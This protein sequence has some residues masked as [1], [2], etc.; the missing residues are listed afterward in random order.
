MQ[1]EVYCD[2]S[3]PDLLT[4]QRPTDSYLV[5]GS[6]WLPVGARGRFK[7]QIRELMDR[8]RVGGEVKWQK[9]SPSRVA[10]YQALVRWFA[11][12]GASLRFRGIAVNRHRINFRLHG[13]DREL[14]FYRFYYQL[15]K[16]WL[17]D[18]NQYSVFCDFK[19]NRVPTQLHTLHR[20]LSAAN[21]S[22]Q[23]CRVQAIRSAESPLLQATDVLTGALS[24]RINSAL[25]PNSAK[26]E[27]VQTLE[28]AL[29]HRIRP[30][31]R[32]Q[33]KF[34]VFRINLRGGW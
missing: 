11:D 20:C 34:N 29:G 15:L 28:D 13:G 10:F 14:A 18:F 1:F 12:A 19:S 3:R 22:A 24:S 4:S 21:L 27:V 2:E 31:A 16:H 32:D 6:L 5:I 26:Q 9:V 8:Y 30:T 25:R 33:P 23:V 7:Q 17:R